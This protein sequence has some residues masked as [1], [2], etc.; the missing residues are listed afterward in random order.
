MSAWSVSVAPGT[1]NAWSPLMVNIIGGNLNSLYLP[2]AN[3][4]VVNA[5]TVLSKSALRGV[6]DYTS[7]LYSNQA[8]WYPDPALPAGG[9]TFNVFNLDPYVWFIHRKLGLTAYAFSLDDDIGN[10]QG[11]G[12]NQMNIGVGGLGG[13]VNT[14]PYT[15]TSQW[16]IVT[17][18]S[19]TQ[20]GTSTLATLTN[21]NVVGQILGFDYSKNLAGTIVNGTGVAPGTYTQFTSIV[22]SNLAQSTITLSS[23]LASGG[24]GQTYDFF[25]PLVFIATV[26]SFQPGQPT[27]VIYLKG[28]QIHDT[29]S[30]VGPLENLQV[31]GEGIDP[32]QTVTITG[33]S[34]NPQ[35]QIFTIQ[36]SSNLIASQISEP[37]GFYAFTFGN[38]PIP[39]VRD[40]GFEWISVQ[41]GLGY[42][43]GQQLSA[44]VP[45][46]TFTD[47]STNE[48]WF[49][50]I[51]YNNTSPY[52]SQNP[53]APQG[54]QVGFIQG[55]SSISQNV[56]L[57]QGNYTLKL[58]AARS[59]TFPSG[60]TL[61]IMLGTTPIGI[62]A[63]T[64]THV[65]AICLQP[66]GPVL[67]DVRPLDRGHSGQCQHRALRRDR[68][69]ARVPVEQTST[70]TTSSDGPVPGPAG[71]HDG[72]QPPCPRDHCR[73]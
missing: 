35:T 20:A 46:W 72:P 21:P 56:T 3:L 67:G 34:W 50:G 49:A 41:G 17:S 55:D 19:T 53:V 15:A 32:S 54:V 18:D 24:S 30:K 36:L 51:A 63:P 39:A 42:N 58:Q 68:D 22:A 13:L 73:V 11:G 2:N 44:D 33:S 23:P 52:T 37:G 62:V 70:A 66:F 9:Q 64:G 45:D 48:K 47:S 69:P 12:A 43:H 4:D 1:A 16:G 61:R 29:L 7:P 25:G 59:G 5:L 26:P 71:Q 38:A 27:N 14:D 8:L 28:E 65:P 6:P 60:E 57:A 10:V 40:P 31:T